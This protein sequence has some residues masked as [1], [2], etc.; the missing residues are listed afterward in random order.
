MTALQQ[1]ISAKKAALA[2]VVADPLATLARRCAEAW[3]DADR[4]D[5]IL[6]DSISKIPNCD[7]LYIW[8]IQGI[9]VS[10]IVRA[11]GVDPAWRGRDLSQRPYLKHS[12][13][14]K[15]VMLSTVYQSLYTRKRCIT[16]LQAI[17]DDNTLLGF[18][19][20]DFVM[21]DL[22][23]DAELIAPQEHWRQF[24]G[25]PVV[26]DMVFMQSR[27]P[28]LLD[29]NIDE[30][31]EQI[32]VLVREHGI[33]HTK[34]HFSSGRCSFWLLED[35]YSYRIHGVEEIIDPDLCLA[36]PLHP[37]PEEAKTPPDKVGQVMERF[38]TLRFI[39]ETIYLRSGS[40]NIMNGMIGLT[41]SCDGSHYMSVEELLEKDIG[42]WLGTLT[43]TDRAA[44]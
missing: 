22:L 32:A 7:V 15:G 6:A 14:F 23:Y 36:Y 17:N 41:F 5:G 2:N 37:Y 26:R 44:T 21:T 38:K 24:R 30:V 13:P 28:S 27:V 20:A 11:S 25:D 4:L 31:L 8:N 34:I 3:P 40:I 19:A 35:P 42:F 39:D 33:F 1:I 29:Q 18:I 9:E 43:P 10:S 16:A 12:L